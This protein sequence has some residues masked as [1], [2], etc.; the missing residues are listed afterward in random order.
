M[1]MMA[2]RGGGG[3]SGLG[4]YICFVMLISIGYEIYRTGSHELLAP[5]ETNPHVYLYC[6]T[7]YS[8]FP[9]MLAACTF[10]SLANKYKV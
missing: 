9:D 4:R 2:R 3:I 1:S 10:L 6:N 7:F 8:Y 5:K